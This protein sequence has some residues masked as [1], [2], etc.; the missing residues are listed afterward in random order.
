M[1][2]DVVTTLKSS[3]AG[4]VTIKGYTDSIG[5]DSY[6]QT[7]SQSRAS[8]VQTFLQANVGNGALAYQA[9]GFGKADPVA[10]NTNPDG[11]DNAAGRQQNRRVVIT[12][13]AG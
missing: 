7:L 12:Y 10:P 8:S 3:G 11:S 5:T 9:Q 2:G 4:T 1:L 6:N 13:A